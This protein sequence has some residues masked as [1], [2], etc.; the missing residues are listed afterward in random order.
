[1][2]DP[3]CLF[4]AHRLD[5]R[6]KKFCEACIP[7]YGEWG[8][9]SAYARRY[10]DLNRA[11]GFQSPP[12][13]SKLPHN[14]PARMVL[15]D[16]Q[17]RECSQRF[18][19]PANR[20]QHRYCSKSCKY[21][22]AYLVRQD[23]GRV[24]TRRAWATALTKRPCAR[25]FKEF[26]AASPAQ[27]FCTQACHHAMAQHLRTHRSPNSCP[28]P[29]CIDCGL[30]FGASPHATGAWSDG[31]RCRY[32]LEDGGNKEARRLAKRLGDRPTVQRLAD[33]DGA[34]CH[35]CLKPVDMNLNGHQWMGPTID[36]L[37]PISMGGADLMLNT[38]L[39]HRKC[40]VE[41]NVKPLAHGAQ[42]RL[43]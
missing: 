15:A 35:L 21:R 42:L 22:Q 19:R 9:K 7:P 27:R 34:I 37:Q 2:A 25:C 4:C 11:C 36:H 28:L 5:G 40:N 20:P 32:C 39:A 33:R 24:P 30:V 18:L 16:C 31:Q 13:S 10:N 26:D 29:V 8:D 17:N 1:M 43:V 38:A 14:H 41:R 6:S 23:R 3:T 12:P